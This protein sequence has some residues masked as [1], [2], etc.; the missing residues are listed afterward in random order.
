MTSSRCTE[1]DAFF[2]APVRQSLRPFLGMDKRVPTLVLAVSA[3]LPFLLSRGVRRLGVAR[4]PR[5]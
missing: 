1:A 2:R 4:R 3:D 5:D